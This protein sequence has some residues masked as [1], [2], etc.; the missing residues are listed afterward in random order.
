MATIEALLREAT[1]RLRDA[2]SATPRLDAEL[3][4]GNVLDLDR[5]RVIAHADAPVGD[6]QAAR[7]RELV[8]RRAAGEPVAYIRGIKE[9][10]G[11]AYSVD[12]R[13]LI[14]RPE[15]ERLVELAEDAIARRLT[16]V[17]RLP[18]T[19]PLLVVDVGTGS[20]AVAVALAVALRR[21]GMLGAV[22][23]LATDV[24]EEALGLA[25]ENVVSHVVADSVRLER[26]DLL[27]PD[28]TLYDIVVANL[29]YVRSAVLPTLPIATSFEPASALDGGPDGLMVVRRLLAL[30]P[31]RLAPDG[32]ALLEIG[33]DQGEAIVAA[34]RDALPGWR[35]T[36][37]TDLAGLPRVARIEPPR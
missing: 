22:S 4:L 7:F 30:L 17:P 35:C 5:T 16:A 36:V 2:G 32:L 21:R 9:F 34:A 25:A 10:H 37:E 8:E 11:L 1:S 12:R 33:A 3:L 13:A 31:S 6:G 20:G 15:T 24:S 28:G 23:I 29:P 27:P 14:P 26:A 19:A 18:G